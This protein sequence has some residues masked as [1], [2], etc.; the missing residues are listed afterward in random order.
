MRKAALLLIIVGLA[1]FVA[2][3]ASSMPMGV[4]YT[5]LQLPVAATGNSGG[6]DMKVGMSECTSIL[7]MVAIGDASI[8][9]AMDNGRITKIHHVDWQAKNILG[10]YGMYNC[11]VYGE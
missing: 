6:G 2:G 9:Q 8:K 11:T 7:G 3:C 5:E 4:L 1:L 10:I